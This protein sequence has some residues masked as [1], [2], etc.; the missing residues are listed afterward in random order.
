MNFAI[1]GAGGYI[2]EK[3]LQ[4]IKE[5]GNELVVAY[6]IVDSVGVLDKYFIN[7]HF[8]LHKEE[9]WY[10]VM[11]NKVDYLV[12]CT[13][14]YTHYSYIK[15]A[16]LL[17]LKVICEKP[18]V[19]KYDLVKALEKLPYQKHINTIMQLR[20]NPNFEQM[21]QRALK[22]KH[23][24]LD[25]ITPRGNW[26][27]SSWKGSEYLSGGLEMNIGIHS[28]DLLIQF[29]GYPIKIESVEMI[30]RESVIGH[31]VFENGHTVDWV[32]SVNPESLSCR[33]LTDKETGEFIDL[34]NSFTNLHTKSYEEILKG[35]GFG[36]ESVKDS[37]KLV[38]EVKRERQLLR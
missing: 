5:T 2:A 36:L 16:L 7:A 32:L 11:T 9:F 21:K 3:H 27:F 10:R 20:L 28:F 19:H 24:T 30:D 37:I 35:N 17:G 26:Y 22:S 6:D 31:F 25:Y 8:T 38:E 1:I 29:F 14:N 4:A 33:K 12:I 23:W 15:K 13:P 18:L 34:S